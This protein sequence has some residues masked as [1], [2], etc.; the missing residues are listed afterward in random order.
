[1]VL[2]SSSRWQVCTQ[3]SPCE[4]VLVRAIY[5]DTPEIAR[6]D[7]TVSPAGANPPLPTGNRRLLGLNDGIHPTSRVSGARGD[8]ELDGLSVT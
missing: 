3:A 5:G 2:S 7:G 1:M 8:V 6:V 4:T